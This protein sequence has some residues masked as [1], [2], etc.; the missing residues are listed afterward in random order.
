MVWKIQNFLIIYS[1]D[2][3]EKFYKWYGSVKKMLFKKPPDFVHN[4]FD[5]DFVLKCVE[6]CSRKKNTVSLT[7]LTFI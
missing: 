7:N 4:E 3:I 2:D 1:I 5:R 6:I